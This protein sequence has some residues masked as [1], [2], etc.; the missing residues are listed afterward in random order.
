MRVC[1]EGFVR[2]NLPPGGPGV[3]ASEDG[4]GGHNLVWGFTAEKMLGLATGAPWSDPFV[5]GEKWKIGG[6]L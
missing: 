4:F 5:P 3:R 1:G 6:I 2:P